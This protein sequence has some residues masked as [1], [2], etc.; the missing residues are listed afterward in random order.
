MR[1]DSSRRRWSRGHSPSIFTRR[2]AK[3][4]HTGGFCGR[5]KKSACRTS[6]TSLKYNVLSVT[7]PLSHNLAW[8]YIAVSAALTEVVFPSVEL[9]EFKEK[10]LLTTSRVFGSFLR[11]P[12]YITSLPSAVSSIKVNKISAKSPAEEKH[13]SA[14]SNA[15]LVGIRKK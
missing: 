1:R 3:E 6:K 9:R 8:P 11:S 7:P 15:L 12:F 14:T 13:N 4:S 5:A 2:A 10:R